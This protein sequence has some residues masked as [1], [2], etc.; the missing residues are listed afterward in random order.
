MLKILD[1]LHR[2]TAAQQWAIIAVE[3]LIIVLVIYYTQGVINA[4]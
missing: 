1:K 2:M 3:L 4:R